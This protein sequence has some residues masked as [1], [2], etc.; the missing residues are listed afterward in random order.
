MNERLG[1]NATNTVVLEVP[2]MCMLVNGKLYKYIASLTTA[3]PCVSLVPLHGPPC[4]YST[5]M[6]CG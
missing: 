3:T 4:F 5:G 6:P 2:G 1:L